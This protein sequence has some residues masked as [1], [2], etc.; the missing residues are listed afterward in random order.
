[1]RCLFYEHLPYACALP[2]EGSA[3]EEGGNTCFTLPSN[4]IVSSSDKTDRL[5]MN[6][7]QLK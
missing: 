4:G 5:E 3:N 2:D 1:M 6:G 7:K